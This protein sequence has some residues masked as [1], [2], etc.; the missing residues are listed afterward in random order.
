[1]NAQDRYAQLLATDELAWRLA[2]ELQYSAP[3]KRI[4]SELKKALEKCVQEM[5]ESLL[6][7]EIIGE[8]TDDF[9]NSDF[10]EDVEKHFKGKPVVADSESGM[11]CIYCH[12]DLTKEV[13]A[14][15]KARAKFE[16]LNVH[17]S[18]E[19]SINGL[20]NWSDAR[21]YCEKNKIPVV[22]ALDTKEQ[23][24]VENIMADKAK[25]L[26]KE[27]REKIDAMYDNASKYLSP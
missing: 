16:K 10:D 3:S 26:E 24:E 25:Q 5:P 7:H 27:V 20:L 6:T 17:K 14:F 12:G 21:A 2:Q 15:L 13:V 19:P 11:L 23:I 8:T 1:M 22:L 18:E 4:S 9:G